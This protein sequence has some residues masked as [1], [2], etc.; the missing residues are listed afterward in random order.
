MDDRTTPSKSYQ[1]DEHSEHLCYIISQGFHLADEQAYRALTESPAFECGHCGRRAR[2][3]TNLCH[4][5]EL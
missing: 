5:T 2:D 4:P 3:A 1:D